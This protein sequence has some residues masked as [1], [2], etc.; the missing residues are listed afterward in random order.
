MKWATHRVPLM[1]LALGFTACVTRGDIEEIKETQKKI[2][3]KLEA[4]GGAARAPARPQRPRGPDPSKAYAF[5]V[6]D[7]HQ[8]GPK[9]AWVT[10]IEVSDFQ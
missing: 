3:E 10:I 4:G 8:K 1:L 9:D 2:L 6:G 7:S 5:P